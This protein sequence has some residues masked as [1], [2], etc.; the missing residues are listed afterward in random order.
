MDCI[1]V[2]VAQ[3]APSQTCVQ[4]QLPPPVTTPPRMTPSGSKDLHTGLFDHVVGGCEQ[5]SDQT[6]PIQHA[7]SPP[8]K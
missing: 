3:H 8:L 4:Q 7:L 2:S 6:V 1:Y 5:L